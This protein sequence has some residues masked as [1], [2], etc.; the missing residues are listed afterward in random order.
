MSKVSK[1]AKKL[2][3]FKRGYNV[4]QRNKY[5]TLEGV[6]SLYEIYEVTGKNIDKPRV[7]VD[8]ESVT[9]FINKCET[10]K[11]EAKAL[12]VSGFQHV[13]GVASAHK[14]VLAGA[15]LA[16]RIGD[17]TPSVIKSYLNSK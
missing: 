3:G 9:K 10:G 13:K 15:E 1:S 11:I 14:D 8:E 4:I 12:K 6:R 17:T 2:K 7:F 16:E 5:L